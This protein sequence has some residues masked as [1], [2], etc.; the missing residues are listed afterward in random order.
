MYDIHIHLPKIRAHFC[1]HIHSSLWANLLSCLTAGRNAKV[2]LASDTVKPEIYAHGVAFGL[3]LR[4]AFSRFLQTSLSL[5]STKYTY[6]CA[7]VFF[8]PW[9]VGPATP[10]PNSH[11]VLFFILAWLK[12]REYTYTYISRYRYIE[13]NNNHTLD[14]FFFSLL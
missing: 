11:A 5:Q 1:A 2:F 12:E 13:R 10:P 4:F 7:P 6:V 3:L 8:F 9:S 14:L